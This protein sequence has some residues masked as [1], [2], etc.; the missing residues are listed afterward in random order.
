ME[1]AGNEQIVVFDFDKTITSIDT[2]T[3]LIVY[4]VNQSL[5]RQCLALFLLPLI[6][7]LNVFY[8]SKP[9]AVSL[10]LWVAS[11]GENRRH[12]VKLI[13]CY[14]ELHK[15]LGTHDVMRKRAF[16]SIKLHLALGH[17]VVI[18]SASSRSWIKHML[19]PVL[20]AKVTIIGSRLQFRWQGLVL[21]SWCYGKN[22]LDHFV[23]Y[24]V[25]QQNLRTIYSDSLTDI[26]LMER[27][28][29]RCFINL[30]SG[31]QKDLEADGK[32]Y[33]LEWLY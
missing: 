8:A 26:A 25:S 4:L 6:F 27:A 15:S 24:G 13:K 22:K 11:V 30:S 1:D 33:Y 5:W 19:G 32:F 17:R 9:S 12:L 20:S 7:F 14:A 28:R 29:N 3:R 21:K 16:Y 10:G 31:R 18:V 23:S 2:F